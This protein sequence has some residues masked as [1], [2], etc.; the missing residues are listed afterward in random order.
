MNELAL[1]AG[2][3]GG[4]Y[5][6]LLLGHTPVCAVEILP[7]NQKV[8]LQRQCDGVFPRFPVWDDA[9]T[10]DGNPWR[11]HVDI[12]S[13]GFPCQ[14]I[15]AAG[16]GA[17]INGERSGLWGEMARIIREVQPRYVLV[18]NSPM[19][20]SRGLG[21]VLGDLAAMGFDAKWGVLGAHHVGAPHKRDR[22]WILASAR[23]RDVLLHTEHK[24]FRRREQ[25]PRRACETT[26][27]MAD[28]QS[29][30]FSAGRLTG[31]NATDSDVFNVRAINGG[32]DDAYAHSE[33]QLQPQ[34]IEQDERGR[35]GNVCCEVCNTASQRQQRQGEPVNACHSATD[36]KGKTDKP[37]YVGFNREWPPEPGVGRVVNGMADRSNRL[38]A[39]GNGQVPR[40]VSTAWS[41]LNER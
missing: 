27:D 4:L 26:A 2:G 41:I 17:G 21:R 39:L 18:E 5:G 25:Q 35:L 6:S 3:G 31:R 7:Y 20:T 37:E 22:I 15:S 1:F 34:G 16:K 33:R 28:A 12:V 14:D 11:G 24:E 23:Q 9:R 36:G 32:A 10:F 29:S 40:V 19:L 8:L 38:I 30:G 13:G